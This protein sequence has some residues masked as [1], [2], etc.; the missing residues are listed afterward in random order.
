MGLNELLF[1]G[2]HILVF[3]QLR[4]VLVFVDCNILFN[5]MR[6]VCLLQFGY[7]LKQNLLFDFDLFGLALFN[8]LLFHS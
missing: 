7:L 3:V 4:Q 8:L 5:Y 2:M 6:F 1:L